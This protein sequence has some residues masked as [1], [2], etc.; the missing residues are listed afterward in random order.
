MFYKGGI[1]METQ[2]MKLN[3]V[4][5]TLELAKALSKELFPGSVI[6]LE[7]ALGAGKTT[8]TKGVAEGLGITRIIKSP[9]Y[10]LIREYDNDPLSLYHVDLFRLEGGGAEDLGLDEYFRQEGVVVIEWGSVAPEVVPSDHLLIEIEVQGEEGEEREFTLTPFGK[11]YQELL[12]EM[13]RSRNG[14]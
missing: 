3:G 2:K 14:S 8:F 5:E 9:S 13:M 11:N 6:L 12:K 10:T 7:G 1:R 4:E